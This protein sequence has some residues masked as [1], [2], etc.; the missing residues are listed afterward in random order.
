MLIFILLVA[1]NNWASSDC[2][3]SGD[4]LLILKWNMPGIGWGFDSRICTLFH[5]Y[6]FLILIGLAARVITATAAGILTALGA[7]VANAVELRDALA[8]RLSSPPDAGVDLGGHHLL[9]QFLPAQS[10]TRKIE[11]LIAQYPW[12]RHH[13][14]LGMTNIAGV[15]QWEDI[16]EYTQIV[17]IKKANAAVGPSDA[18]SYFNS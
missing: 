17:N 12:L 15:N 1:F 2:S 5:N 11:A 8:L 7:P 6:Y 10:L 13:G 9:F 4:P 18:P 14:G 3:F 16:V